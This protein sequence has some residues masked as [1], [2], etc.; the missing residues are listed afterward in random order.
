MTFLPYSIL[1]TKPSGPSFNQQA[2]GRVA[3]QA[4]P[5]VLPMAP[6]TPNNSSLCLGSN[7]EWVHVPPMDLLKPT[8]ACCGDDSAAGWG[9][10]GLVPEPHPVC[11]CVPATLIPL[12]LSQHAL[13]RQGEQMPTCGSLGQLLPV[14]ALALLG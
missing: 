7:R 5:G 1:F 3:T 13:R 10:E 11:V 2:R 4:D 12:P 6:Q 8:C 9:G 14:V